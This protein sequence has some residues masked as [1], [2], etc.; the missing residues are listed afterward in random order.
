MIMKA[1]KISAVFQLLYCI[2]CLTTVISIF[3][4]SSFYTTD[5]GAACFGISAVMNLLSTVIPTGLVATIV[6]YIAY[7]NSDLRK[8]KTALVW[9]IVA[10]I[11]I[12]LSWLL[13]VS[14]FVLYTGGV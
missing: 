13:S 14:T 6:N 3:L 5:F 12:I 4:Y 10:P 11:M 2:G 1:F 7:F 8:S 9:L